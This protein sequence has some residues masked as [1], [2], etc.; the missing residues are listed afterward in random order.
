MLDLLVWVKFAKRAFSRDFRDSGDSWDYWAFSEK[1]GEIMGSAP[2]FTSVL[3]L[4]C[5]SWTGCN[6]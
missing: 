4:V 6:V 2:E 3:D 1:L 5:E